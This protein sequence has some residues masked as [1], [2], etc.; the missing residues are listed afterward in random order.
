MEF[1]RWFV[2]I[3]FLSGRE[4]EPNHPR[5]Q[6]TEAPAISSTTRRPTKA[7]FTASRKA[8]RATNRKRA[9]ATKAISP[10]VMAIVIL[11]LFGRAGSSSFCL[12]LS[13]FCLLVF[14]AHGRLDVAAYVKVAF[15][16]HSN[17]IAG[18][19]K[20]LEDHVDYVFV[21]DLHFAK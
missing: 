16:L 18:F 5:H 2:G 4:A 15:D 1:V 20:V 3:G 21:K 14:R 17:R 6:P 9:T 13:A 8:R 7:S 19:H 10:V 12:L 11:E